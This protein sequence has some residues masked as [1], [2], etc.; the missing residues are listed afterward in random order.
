MSPSTPYAPYTPHDPFRSAVG[1][2]VGTPSTPN[3]TSRLERWGQQRDDTFKRGLAK[4]RGEIIRANG[5]AR[6]ANW[7]AAEMGRGISFGVTLQIPP[8]NLLCC[9]LLAVGLG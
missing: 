8:H 4:L 9:H 6:E 1:K 5:L 3:V 7:L 2:P